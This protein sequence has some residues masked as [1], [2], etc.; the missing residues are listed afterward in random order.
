MD[1]GCLKRMEFCLIAVSPSLIFSCLK[2]MISEG[3]FHSKDLQDN[4][5]ISK[6][7]KD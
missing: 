3:S 2:L 5:Y 7:Y 1:R 6:V 4:Q